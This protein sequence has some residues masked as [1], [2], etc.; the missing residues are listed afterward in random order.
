MAADISDTHTI[1]EKFVQEIIESEEFFKGDELSEELQVF[2]DDELQIDDLET[3]FA[4]QGTNCYEQ[5]LFK[6]GKK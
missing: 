5:F 4:A 2:F 3:V 1:F 6:I